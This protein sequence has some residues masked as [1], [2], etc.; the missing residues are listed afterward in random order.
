MP[1]QLAHLTSLAARTN[2]TIQVL[3]LTTPWPV[4]S[5]PF[6]LLTFPETADPETACTFSHSGDRQLTTSPG[7][8]RALTRTFTAISRAAPAT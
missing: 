4:T 3:P 6:T 5:S 7:H 8:V 1:A 2:I